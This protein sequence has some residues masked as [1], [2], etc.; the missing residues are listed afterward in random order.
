MPMAART[1]PTSDNVIA[2]KLGEPAGSEGALQSRTIPIRVKAM[3]KRT[4]KIAVHKVIGIDARGYQTT[5]IRFPAKDGLEKHLNKIYGDPAN[6]DV[7]VIGG[8]VKIMADGKPAYGAHIGSKGEGKCLLDGDLLHEL[9]LPADLDRLLLHTFA[10]EI[11]HVMTTNG[12]P[13]EGGGFAVLKW[14][15]DYGPGSNTTDVRDKDRLMCSGKNANL[16][17]PGTQLIKKEW[18]Q[19]EAWLKKEESRLGRSL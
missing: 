7:W 2:L 5:P 9:G 4:V 17:N 11:G 1:G 6:I 8:G 18:G 12:H 16:K 13:D 15:T 3:K 14:K 10:H 19:I